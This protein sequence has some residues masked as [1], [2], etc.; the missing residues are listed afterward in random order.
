M[1]FAQHLLI[2]LLLAAVVGLLDFQE[3]AT[4]G[5]S[6]VKGLLV[7]PFARHERRVD[8]RTDFRFDII[9]LS[10]GEQVPIDGGKADSG[11]DGALFGGA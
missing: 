5:L 8:A 3:L 7:L 10:I 4:C 2:L 6:K 11:F 1:T 9:G